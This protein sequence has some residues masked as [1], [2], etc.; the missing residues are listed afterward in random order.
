MLEAL[1]NM[2]HSTN[3]QYKAIFNK[4][5]RRKWY[6][7]KFINHFHFPGRKCPSWGIGVIH[8]SGKKSAIGGGQHE[9]YVKINYGHISLE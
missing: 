6:K 7:F 1:K 9:S 2:P 4:N 8:T 3:I 5:W